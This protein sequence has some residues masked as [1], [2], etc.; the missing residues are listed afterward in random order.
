M[1]L[2]ILL[3]TYNNQATVAQMVDI[4]KKYGYPIVIVNDGSD[5]DTAAVLSRIEQPGVVTVCHRKKNGGKGR[6]VMDGL[7]HAH[8][9]G[10]THVLQLDA[11]N[12]HCIEDIPRF[13]AAADESPGALILG[14]PI[15]P[16]NVP[17]ARLNGRKIS[18]VWVWIETLSTKIHDPLFGFRLY[19]VDA[20]LAASRS[21]FMG[22]RMDFDPEIAV[23]LVWRGVDVIN[24]KTPVTYHAQG[25]SH[26]HYF[27]DNVRISWMHTRLFL[28]MLVR[29]WKLI[30]R[31]ILG[32][33]FR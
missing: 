15:F 12:Q 24:V 25:V 28:G 19:P 27:Y 32:Q 17:R 20:A 16:E 30:G 9:H 14:E 7:R 22:Y 23:R 29:S 5:A 10:F 2:C 13:V 31:L 11:D 8:A 21:P 6:A 3:P 1:K 4:L 33:I 18:I 26:F